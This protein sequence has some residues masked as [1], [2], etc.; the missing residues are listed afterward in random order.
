MIEAVRAPCGARVN[1]DC[2]AGVTTPPALSGRRCGKCLQGVQAGGSERQIFVV[3]VGF[4]INGGAPVAILEVTADLSGV[5]G[6]DPDEQV[7]DEE[8]KLEGCGVAQGGQRDYS[9]LEARKR[10]GNTP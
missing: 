4:G 1:D 3:R 8:V 2:G 6:L 9:G 7:F 5:V 10:L